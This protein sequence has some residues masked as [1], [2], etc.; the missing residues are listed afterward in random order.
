MPPERL[1]ENKAPKA[2]RHCRL[3]KRR[4][5]K[6]LPSC[7]TC[8]SKW[9]RCEYDDDTALLETVEPDT[10]LKWSEPLAIRRFLCG[11]ELTPAG[12]KQLLWTVCQAKGPWNREPDS[13]T[14]MGLVKDIFSYGGTTVEQVTAEYFA[15]VHEWMPIVDKATVM[16]ELDSIS[17]LGYTGPRDDSL[18]LLLLCMD[19][20]NHHCR[21]PNHGPNN[22]LYRTTRRLF[23]L[24]ETSGY[25]HLLAKLQAGL[26]LTTYEC[27][28]GMVVEAS[29]TLATCLGLVRQLDMSALQSSATGKAPYNSSRNL[30]WAAIVFLDR[31]ITLSCPDGTATLL[32]P[33]RELLPY[34]LIPYVTEVNSTEVNT[35][36]KFQARVYAALCIGEAL[37]AVQGVPDAPGCA[38]AE[39]LLH[40]LVRQHAETSDNK[41][42]YPVCEGMAMALSAVVSLYKRR[43]KDPGSAADAKLTLDIKFAYNIAFAMCRVEGVLIKKRKG[44]HAHRLCFSGLSCLYRAAVDLDEICPNGSSPEDFKQL[45]E[46]LKWFSRHWT[47]ADRLLWRNTCNWR[48]RV[49]PRPF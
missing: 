47:V 6:K 36:T 37:T 41:D 42:I 1:F 11:L 22:T 43:V 25:P 39:K 16:S 24:V 33:T 17:L 48:E 13:K 30:C 21:H 34:D 27:G 45:R 3:H 49:L 12:G 46:N 19:M 40:D 29:L 44:S 23:S 26:L 31:A 15:K 2:C 32:I 20:V 8:S 14:V 7:S 5:D 18:A 38:A 28:H 4:C 10:E 35:E 9:T